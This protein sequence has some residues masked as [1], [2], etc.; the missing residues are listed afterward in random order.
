M[1]VIAVCGAGGLDPS[2]PVLGAL[3]DRGV[4]VE[5]LPDE[6]ELGASTRMEVEQLAKSLRRAEA[7]LDGQPAEG[8]LSAGDGD[9]DLA[10]ALVAVKRG[11]AVIRLSAGSRGGHGSEETNRRLVDRLADLRICPDADARERLR[12][13][14]LAEDAVVVDPGDPGA[15]AGAIAAWLQDAMAG[16]GAAES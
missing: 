2:A 12:P 5:P 11:T 8:L 7:A 4:A 15:L 1:R 16:P 10:A 3:L 9:L 13:E 6:V 14:G